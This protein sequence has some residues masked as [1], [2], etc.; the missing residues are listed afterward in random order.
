[1]SCNFQNRNSVCDQNRTAGIP[2]AIRVDQPLIGGE[3]W[4]YRFGTNPAGASLSSPADRQ[5]PQIPQGKCALA[6]CGRSLVH[7]PESPIGPAGQGSP[8]W[9]NA[10]P[11]PGICL[12][13]TAKALLR[14][15]SQVYLSR[16]CLVPVSYLPC[17]SR[18]TWEVRDRYETGTRQGHARHTVRRQAERGR[19][20]RVLS[21]APPPRRPVSL[22]DALTL[23]H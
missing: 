10:N 22:P 2:L 11:C 9:H 12:V 5:N 23:I 16:T 3:Q 17:G 21:W 1:M 20:D 15:A 8:Y 18:S 7:R 19:S 14:R 4:I 13:W 6:T